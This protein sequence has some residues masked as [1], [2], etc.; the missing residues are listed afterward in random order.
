LRADLPTAPL[1]SSGDKSFEANWAKPR[2]LVMVLHDIQ[3]SFEISLLL[4]TL[5]KS[6][7]AA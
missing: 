3:G 2:Q 6:N 5:M 7:F 4:E 1:D